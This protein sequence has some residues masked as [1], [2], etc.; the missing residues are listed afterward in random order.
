MGAEL[1]GVVTTLTIVVGLMGSAVYVITQARSQERSLRFSLV[2]FLVIYVYVAAF[3]GMLVMAVGGSQAVNAG[4]SKIISA[5][6]S[7]GRDLIREPSPVKPEG[8]GPQNAER[9]A[10]KP[11]DLDDAR[12]RQSR[13][14]RENRRLDIE[15]R[16]GLWQGLAL[17]VT[18]A[19]IYGFHLGARLLLGSVGRMRE[20]R[21]G[22]LCVMLA[23]F[24]LVSILSIPAAVA[25]TM[26][27]LVHITS[28]H[29]PS[30]Y[31]PAAGPV[32]ANV[33][34][35]T[36]IWLVV[37]VLLMRQVRRSA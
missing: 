11:Q 30:D 37:L 32:V 21:V 35:F 28:S 19:V 20:L 33:I 36:P 24:G 8:L 5:E 34:V 29:N 2:G 26:E 18:G 7:Y 15:F 12:G 16:V 14:D 13:I 4:L 27:H 9:Q 25:E 17:A 6:F 3:A 10:G 23:V 1:V 31:V 22:Y